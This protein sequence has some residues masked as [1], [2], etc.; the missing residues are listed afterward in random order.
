MSSSSDKSIIPSELRRAELLDNTAREFLINAAIGL[1]VGGL[2]SL[3]LFRNGGNR[4]LLIG[5]CTG[6]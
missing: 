3:V 5:F 1:T 2:S 6:Y 4:K